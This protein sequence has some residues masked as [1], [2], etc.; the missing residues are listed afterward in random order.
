MFLPKKTGLSKNNI[1]YYV[2]GDIEDFKRDFRL[3]K[4]KIFSNSGE[5]I[6]ANDPKEKSSTLN[7]SKNKKQHAQSKRLQF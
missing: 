1:R 4:L 7:Y 3:T 6:F 5:I 2:S